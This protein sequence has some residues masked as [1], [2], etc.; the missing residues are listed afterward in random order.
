MT[1]LA[2]ETIVSEYI[3]PTIFYYVR[4]LDRCYECT[5]F[6]ARSATVIGVCNRLADCEG[7]DGRQPHNLSALL[8]L[9]APT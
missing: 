7:I 6:R 4:T 8:L 2:G 9:A 1:N 3:C 5:A